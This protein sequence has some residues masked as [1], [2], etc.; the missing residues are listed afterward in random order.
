VWS[1]KE[2]QGYWKLDH[3]LWRTRFKKVCGPVVEVE[4]AQLIKALYYNW[5]RFL[6]RSL[7]F[8]FNLI[9][10]ASLWPWGRLRHVTEM[11]T[12]DISFGIA[13]YRRPEV[14]RADNLTT[15]MCRLSVHSGRH[16]LLEP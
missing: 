9:L 15:F 11:C 7:R 16:N 6:I 1:L 4:V 2:T 12:R 3:T 13:G 5:F 8:F 10:Q 14:C